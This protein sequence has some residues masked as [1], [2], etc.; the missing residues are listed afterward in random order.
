MSERPPASVPRVAAAASAFPPHRYEQGVLLEELRG[1]WDG[2]LAR[3]EVLERFHARVG[4]EA[5]HLALPREAYRAPLDF[6]HANDAWIEAAV[7]LGGEAL[8]AA[9]AR[10]GVAPDELSALI[11]VSVTGVASP[12]V[13]ARL[14]NRLDLS[15]NVRRVPV[16]GLGCVGGASGLALAADHVRAHPDGVAAVVAVELCSLTF[17]RSDLSGAN[18][19]A[20]GLFADGAAAAVVRAGG[21]DGGPRI[22][23][24]RPVFYPHTEHVMGW[25]VGADGFR[26]VLSREVPDMVHRHLAADVDDFLADHGLARDD[27]GVW[28]L[29]PGGPAVLRAYESA[30][31]L[32]PGATDESWTCLREVGNLSSASV[33]VVLE[34][35]L[36]RRRPAPGT[37]GLLAAM[38]PGFCAELVL[39]RW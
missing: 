39:L 33:L 14:I 27:V 6:T 29:H 4:V 10:A 11:F 8:S 13:D 1:L 15:P 3:P 9:L 19:I 7:A 36:A 12:S 26:L 38:G 35:T 25:A 30:L 32:P 31:R 22:A 5:R 28:I 23:G 34:R 16:F 24:T 18:L 20:S 21:A 17:Q 2:R 37:V